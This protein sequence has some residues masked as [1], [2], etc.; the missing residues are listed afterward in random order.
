[1]ARSDDKT[2][3]NYG[4]QSF[5]LIIQLSGKPLFL[6][7]CQESSVASRYEVSI[8]TCSST[9]V[10]VLSV[11]AYWN[12]SARYGYVDGACVAFVFTFEI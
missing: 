11:R 1:M 8:V 12:A 3:Q 7:C 4:N 9:F 5:L 10:R 2:G 6:C